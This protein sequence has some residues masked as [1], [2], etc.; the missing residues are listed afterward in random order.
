MVTHST[1]NLHITVIA[2]SPPLM[3]ILLPQVSISGMPAITWDS[4]VFQLAAGTPT[5]M[6]LTVSG[7]TSQTCDLVNT[8]SR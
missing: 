1:D 3:F 4:R 8:S 7:W 5:A 2:L 6:T